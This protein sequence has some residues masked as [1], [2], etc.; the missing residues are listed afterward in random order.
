MRVTRRSEGRRGVLHS[1]PETQWTAYLPLPN[2]TRWTASLGPNTNSR[3]LPLQPGVDPTD[4]GPRVLDHPNPAH[5]SVNNLLITL[6]SMTYFFPFFP[7]ERN[8]TGGSEDPHLFQL[9]P[10]EWPQRLSEDLGMQVCGCR[11]ISGRRP[12][13]S[14]NP[15]GFVTNQEDA[16][17]GEQKAGNQN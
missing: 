7:A 2:A 8:L 15:A 14:H 1:L 9:Q 13:G 11:A 16:I 5:T 17:L 10:A 12:L 3:R 4:T 6:Y